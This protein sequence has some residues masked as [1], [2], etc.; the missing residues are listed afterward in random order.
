MNQ[1]LSVRLYGKQVGLLEQTKTGKLQFTY[2]DLNDVAISNSLPLE[3]KTF[4]DKECKPYF[5]GLLPESD[6][7]RKHIGKM[8]GIN[9]NNDFALLKAIGD[10]CAGALSLHDINEPI[11]VK[12][13]IELEATPQTDEQFAKHIKE[14]PNKPFFT[15]L[16]N[17][18]RLSLAGTQ[19]KGAVTIIDGKICLPKNNTPTTHIV[20]PLIRNLEN[21]ILNEYLCM[22]VAKAIGINTAQVEMCKVKD[23][24]YLL[25]E[26]YDREVKDNKIKR[27]HQEDFCQALSVLSLS[28]YQADGGPDIK[29][30]FDLLDITKSPANSRNMLMKLIIF[31]FLTGNN[32]AHA[33]NFSL[34]YF[35]KKP[36]LAPAYDLLSTQIYP[37]LTKKMAMKIGSGYEKKFVTK[38]GF[39]KMCE[40]INYS[41]KMFTKEFEE[42]AD[43]L[44]QMLEKEVL[45]LDRKFSGTVVQKI[46]SVI[47]ENSK[48]NL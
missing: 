33:K 36:V 12:E 35:K 13:F 47:T 8:F 1:R 24:Q 22:K 27:I 5:N 2:E 3:K 30:C 4:S 40:D 38:S 26:R 32:D 23:V 18:V 7:V 20:K 44:P 42:I 34:L 6:T 43:K 10:D 19:D 28:K 48:I 29:K 11:Q 37:N 46:K 45:S 25:I 14:L 39:E 16:S 41:Y 31:N 21:T 9:S 17:E 15:E